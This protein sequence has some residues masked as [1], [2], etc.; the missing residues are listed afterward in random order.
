MTEDDFKMIIKVMRNNCRAFLSTIDDHG[1]DY[2]HQT[3]DGDFACHI[4]HAINRYDNGMCRKVTPCKSPPEIVA[5]YR[6]L[7]EEDDGA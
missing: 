5:E 3:V 2:D 1:Y 7:Q 6:K 4:L